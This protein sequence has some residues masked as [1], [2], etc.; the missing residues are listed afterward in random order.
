MRL[1]DCCSPNTNPSQEDIQRVYEAYRNDPRHA[2]IEKA[3]YSLIDKQGSLYERVQAKRELEILELMQKDI[4]N[5][6]FD[7]PWEADQPPR[8]PANYIIKDCNAVADEELV[9]ATWEQFHELF[10]GKPPGTL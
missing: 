5:Y 3:R 2:E 8:H 10:N 9:M 7:L 6:Y 4:Y 1:K